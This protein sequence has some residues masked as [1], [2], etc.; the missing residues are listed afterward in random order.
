ME[1][2]LTKIDDTFYNAHCQITVKKDGSDSV[3][4]VK[5]THRFDEPICTA[6]NTQIELIK[7]VRGVIIENDSDLKER[8]KEEFKRVLAKIKEENV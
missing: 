8:L 7:H 1:V 5:E 6:V 3:F 2:T 4:T